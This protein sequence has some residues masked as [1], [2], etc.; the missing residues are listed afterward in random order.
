MAKR[1]LSEALAVGKK[2]GEDSTIRMR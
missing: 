2:T 1:E